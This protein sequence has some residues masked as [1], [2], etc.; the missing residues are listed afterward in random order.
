MHGET[1]KFESAAEN[2]ERHNE[3][4][5]PWKFKIKR[6]KISAKRGQ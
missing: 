2:L 5:L 1:V 4:L 6:K 3:I